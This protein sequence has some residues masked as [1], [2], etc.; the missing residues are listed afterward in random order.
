MPISPRKELTKLVPATH[1]SPDY[2]EMER[3]GLVPEEVIDF[4]VCSNPFGPPS[5]IRNG[6]TKAVIDKYPDTEATELRLALSQ[7]LGISPQNMAVGNGSTE[8][9]RLAAMVYFSPDDTVVIIKPDFGEY[10][11]AS[12]LCGARIVHLIVKPE[13]GFRLPLDKLV[14][15]IRKHKPKGLFLSNPNNPTGQYLSRKE[16]EAILDASSKCLVIVD[17]AYVSF[18]ENDWPSQDLIGRDNLL[19]LRSM[20]KDYT[21]PGLRLGYAMANPEII[22]NLRRAMPPWNVN[23]IALKAGVLALK[24]A[25]FLDI[26]LKKLRWE[27]DALM[28]KIG[29]LYLQTV[30]TQANFFLVKAGNARQFRERLLQQKILV[31]DCTSFGLR[32]YVRI[33]PRTPKENKRLVA[34]LKELNL[35]S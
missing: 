29:H 3:L 17:E 33:A 25:E 22:T 12:R 32:E 5:S 13:D 19:V 7:K 26:S 16:M 11:V 8:L 15:L 35:K 2:A 23:A 4:S 20:T 34:V 21:L 9:I 28:A 18:V 31:R 1:G 10:E 24:D 30:P 14:K 27:R 6:L